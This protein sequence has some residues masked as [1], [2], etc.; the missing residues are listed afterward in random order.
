MEVPCR[1]LRISDRGRIALTTEEAFGPRSSQLQYGWVV[2][3][4]GRLVVLWALELGRFA[5]VLVLSLKHEAC[6]PE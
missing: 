2:L 1:R 4:T 5:Y 3:A 6:V